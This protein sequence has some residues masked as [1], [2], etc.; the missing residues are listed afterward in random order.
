MKCTLHLVAT[1]GTVPES[2]PNRYRAAPF[3]S[4]RRP[5]VCPAPSRPALMRHW[6][7]RRA[8]AQ[9]ID[10]RQ[11]AAPTDRAAAAENRRTRGRVRATLPEKP[12]AGSEHSCCNASSARR[13]ARYS[14]TACCT[15]ISCG[16]WIRLPGFCR[17]LPC[18]GAHPR[19][20]AASVP[21]V[22][23]CSYPPNRKCRPAPAL[24]GLLHGSAS[25]ANIPAKRTLD[26]D[27]RPE[28]AP[29]RRFFRRLCFLP[30]PASRQR[31][32]ASSIS[33]S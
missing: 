29:A 4:H 5:G 11:C 26:I 9:D 10:I 33:I 18:D 2:A 20:H 16:I 22:R 14:S 24:A 19:C 17:F 1:D 32:S 13:C 30:C 27:Q 21:P 6:L 12:T 8:A 23:G 3:R 7:W 15:T 28:R 25:A 31:L